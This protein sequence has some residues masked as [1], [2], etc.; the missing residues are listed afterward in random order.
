VN[1]GLIC[2][3]QREKAGKNKQ[4]QEKNQQFAKCTDTLFLLDGIVCNRRK[5][6]GKQDCNA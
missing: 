6:M 3:E 5:K 1:N 4:K 2:P